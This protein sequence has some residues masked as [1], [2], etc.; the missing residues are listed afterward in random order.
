MSRKVQ[1]YC[2]NGLNLALIF[3][4][5]FVLNSVLPLEDDFSGTLLAYFLLL[6]FLESTLQ[7]ENL[8]PPFK[9]RKFVMQLKGLGQ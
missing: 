2:L 1:L 3:G 9:I 8:D 6:I 4:L 7:E 5:N